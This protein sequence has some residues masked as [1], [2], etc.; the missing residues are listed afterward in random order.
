LAGL[1]VFSRLGPKGKGILLRC[2]TEYI[3]KPKGQATIRGGKIEGKS[4][5]VGTVTGFAAFDP[6]EKEHELRKVECDVVIK[7]S[8]GDVIAKVPCAKA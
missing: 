1:A 6:D 7:D 2:E 5:F 3:K 4:L 8:V